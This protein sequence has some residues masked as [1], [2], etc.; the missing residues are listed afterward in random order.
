MIY[1]L[2]LIAGPPALIVGLSS[3]SFFIF[4]E[5]SRERMHDIGEVLALRE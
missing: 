5:L 4:Y 3:M 1:Y 2:G